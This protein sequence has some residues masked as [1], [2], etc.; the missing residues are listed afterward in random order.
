[1]PNF[2]NNAPSIVARLAKTHYVV[3]L[4]VDGKFTCALDPGLGTV[5]RGQGVFGKKMGEEIVR[6]AAEEGLRGTVMTWEDAL[7]LLVKQC[8]G[9]K[10]IEKYLYDRIVRNQQKRAD[11]KLPPK[12]LQQ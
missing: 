6:D 8:G 9:E 3:I 7:R 4:E 10:Q 12:P 1:M 11:V 2:I 5:W